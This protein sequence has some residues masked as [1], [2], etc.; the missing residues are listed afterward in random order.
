MSTAWCRSR[1]A[2]AFGA[3]GGICPDCGYRLR[4]RTR[5]TRS[6]VKN[7]RMVG[8]EMQHAEVPEVRFIASF[9][10]FSLKDG[11][12]RQRIAKLLAQKLRDE[13]PVWAE[14]AA[15]D[16]AFALLVARDEIER[17]AMLQAERRRAY[18][19]KKRTE[20]LSGIPVCD[21]V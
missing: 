16:A 6:D 17:D 7:A 10:E 20:H 14:D 9:Y 5:Y 4:W 12:K 18:R 2:H 19:E 8:C 11:F 13:H 15:T 21:T 1:H 3:F